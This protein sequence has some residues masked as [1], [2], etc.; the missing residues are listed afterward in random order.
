MVLSNGSMRARH[1][2]SLVNRTDRCGG[3]RKRGLPAMS[4]NYP[5]IA[6]GVACSRAKCSKAGD[7][8]GA[9]VPNQVKL[10]RGSRG[11]TSLG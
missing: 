5:R 3:D 9:G 4:M 7:M 10:S 6:Q 2:S 8:C 11:G 1:V